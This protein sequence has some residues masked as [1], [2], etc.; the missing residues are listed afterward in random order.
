MITY[1]IYIY[2]GIL[3]YLTFNL[4][5][6][7]L[8][9]FSIETINRCK[10]YTCPMSPQHNIGLGDC[11]LQCISTFIN[12]ESVSDEE[13]RSS[14]QSYMQTRNIEGKAFLPIMTEEIGYDPYNIDNM[15]LFLTKEQMESLEGSLD[16]TLQRRIIDN[17]TNPM[18]NRILVPDYTLINLVDLYSK[19]NPNTSR[20]LIIIKYNR[21]S[22][23]YFYHVVIIARTDN[24]DVT[25]IYMLDS[26]HRVIMKN[27]DIWNHPWLDINFFYSETPHGIILE[28]LEKTNLESFKWN[29]ME[30]YENEDLYFLPILNIESMLKKESGGPDLSNPESWNENISID[31]NPRWNEDLVKI[32]NLLK[33]GEPRLSESENSIYNQWIRRL[34][35]GNIIDPKNLYCSAEV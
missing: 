3:L 35:D 14:I 21:L 2:F 11:F 13:W 4:K 7:L 20:I 31:I 28:T 19:L 16:H 26:K 22:R 18:E 30:S 23:L 33:T 12:V 15:S 29:L 24:D 10:T 25:D 5:E 34:P 8:I 9:P 17:Y 27:S 1:L 6:K 32:L